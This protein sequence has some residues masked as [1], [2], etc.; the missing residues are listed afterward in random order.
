MPALVLPGGG[1]RG[2]YHVGVLKALAELPSLTS[3]PR[4]RSSP[5]FRPAQSMPGS[6]PVTPMIFPR[7][8]AAGPYFWGN[9]R[10]HSMCIEPPG[11]TISSSGLHWL[12][13]MTLG[14]LGVA[15]PK[16]LFDNQPLAELLASEPQT[17]CDCPVR[18]VRRIARADDH[19]LGLFNQSGQSPFFSGSADVSGWQAPP[20][21][22]VNRR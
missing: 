8:R 12:A 19:G 2:A 18:R 14:G 6:W 16:S 21:G 7:R 22:L 11:C 20:A 5:V 4:F 15:N 10:C 13:S 3:D 1:A 9:L 17:R